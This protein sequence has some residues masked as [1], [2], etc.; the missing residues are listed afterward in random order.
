MSFTLRPGEKLIRNWS[1]EGKYVEDN[2]EMDEPERYGNGRLVFTPLLTQAMINDF[3]YD[4]SNLAYSASS[5]IV[6]TDVVVNPGW[7]TYE[8]TSPHPIASAYLTGEF[9]RTS[10]DSIKAYVSFDGVSDWTNIWTASNTGTFTETVDFSSTVDN[11]T[12]DDGPAYK[13]YIKVEMDGT[14]AGINSLQIDTVVQ[15]A[16]RSLPALD[17]GQNTVVYT[18]ESA[19]R[20]I[21][22]EYT[23][24]PDAINEPSVVSVT[25]AY[26]AEFVSTDTTIDIVLDRT[27]DSDEWH[28][29]NAA[30]LFSESEFIPC[31]LVFNS[32]TDTFTLTPVRSLQPDTKYTF[33]LHRRAIWPSP[34]RGYGYKPTGSINTVFY[35]GDAPN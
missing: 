24:I 21:K 17:L 15:L 33:Y 26:G 20:N 12:Y 14:G 5:P 8:V 13:Y 30:F 6:I 4:S 9:M 2:P 23:Y 29:D 25:P 7:I 3:A 28:K 34:V 35:T 27:P 1:N 22:V 11:G 16:I 31:T 32:G 18:D 19:S 10:S